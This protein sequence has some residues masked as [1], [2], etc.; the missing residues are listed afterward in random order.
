MEDSDLEEMVLVDDVSSSTNGDPE[1]QA[2]SDSFVNILRF[3]PTVGELCSI[4]N[5]TCSG[6]ENFTFRGYTIPRSKNAYGTVIQLY[7]QDP[8]NETG[9][10]QYS[11]Y[12]AVIDNDS[13]L[14]RFVSLTHG[15]DSSLAT[16]IA[17]PER[18]NY[19][20][21][22]SSSGGEYPTE[23]ILTLLSIVCFVFIVC[24]CFRIFIYPFYRRI[25][26]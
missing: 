20:Y 1:A 24:A 18:L 3:P 2:L 4:L 7:Y 10:G 13:K 15:S 6:E 26:R 25:S 22:V 23:T 5:R 19:Y 14:V 17:T 21:G 11:V 8:S 9:V 16:S 12:S